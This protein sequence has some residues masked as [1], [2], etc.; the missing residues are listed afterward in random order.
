MNMNPAWL[1]QHH[2]G[3]AWAI[4]MLLG[5]LPLASLALDLG[6]GTLGI[7]PLERLNHTTGLWAFNLLLITL[8]VTPLRRLL[9]YLMAQTA[10]S[11][12]KRLSDWNSL[13]RLRRTFGLLSFVYATAHVGIYLCLEQACDLMAAL[14]E[15]AAKRHLAVGTA[16]FVLMLPLAATSTFAMM[17]RL[18]R[19]WKRLHRSVYLIGATASL[20]YLWAEK[21]GLGTA[22]YYVAMIG[23][24]LAYRVLARFG[25][26]FRRPRDGGE[27]VAERGGKSL[28][29]DP[30]HTDTR[31]ELSSQSPR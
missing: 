16:A 30:P 4:V 23:A 22:R 25:L 9:A 2:Y 19:N 12:G 29:P 7:N 5:S 13:I 28:K 26:M 17:R 18:G 10:S 24:L 11:F 31:N 8:A 27:E 3:K 14:G 6:Q 21:V 15:I 1:L 20:H